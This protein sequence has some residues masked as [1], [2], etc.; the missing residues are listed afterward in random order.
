M[1]RMILAVALLALLT[2]CASRQEFKG[3][4]SQARQRIEQQN[5]GYQP[6]FS[7]LWVPPSAEVESGLF[8]LTAGASGA[9]LGFVL[10][11][12]KGRRERD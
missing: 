5:P 3:T 1:R 4:D 6:W 9:L 12:R 8:A 10:G 2:G 11:L 7:P